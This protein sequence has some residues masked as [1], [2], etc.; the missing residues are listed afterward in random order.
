[1]RF[2]S[3]NAG[4]YAEGLGLGSGPP[5]LL[6]NYSCNYFRLTLYFLQGLN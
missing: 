5:H 6:T 4:F 3:D 1:M 2:L